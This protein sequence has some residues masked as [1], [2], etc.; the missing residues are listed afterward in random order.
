[1]SVCVNVREKEGCKRGWK[2]RTRAELGDGDAD[3][4]ELLC[5]AVEREQLALLAL[6]HGEHRARV[7]LERHHRVLLRQRRPEQ[8]IVAE[9]A[10]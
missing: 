4:A 8:S 5:G 7:R 3:K 1:M 9:E 6:Q 10:A 2:Q